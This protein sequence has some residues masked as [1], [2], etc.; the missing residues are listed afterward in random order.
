MV[1]LQQR[2]FVAGRIVF[3]QAV[4]DQRV[5][6]TSGITSTDERPEVQINSAAFFVIF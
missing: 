6:R 1:D 4:E 2:F 5:V 3:L